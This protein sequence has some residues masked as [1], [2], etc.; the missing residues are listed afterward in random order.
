M[1]DPIKEIAVYKTPPARNSNDSDSSHQGRGI[2]VY[3]NTHPTQAPRQSSRSHVV[4]KNNGSENPT[5]P[6]D[7][8]ERQSAAEKFSGDGKDLHGFSV[9]SHS[10]VFTSKQVLLQQ[11]QAETKDLM[12]SFSGASASQLKNSSFTRNDK[13][14][15]LSQGLLSSQVSQKGVELSGKLENFTTWSVFNQQDT[16]VNN[17]ATNSLR[18][19]VETF[20]N[21]MRSSL[22]N[23][24]SSTPINTLQHNRLSQFFF[25][26]TKLNSGAASLASSLFVNSSH[27]DTEGMHWVKWAQQLGLPIQNMHSVMPMLTHFQEASPAAKS[28]LQGFMIFY[29]IFAGVSQSNLSN[30]SWML[31]KGMMILETRTQLNQVHSPLLD[32]LGALLS[33]SR[34][35]LRRQNRKRASGLDKVSRK[36]SCLA[37]MDAQETAPDDEALIDLWPKKESNNPSMSFYYM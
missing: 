12:K 14:G 10:G 20:P 6:Q 5:E 33:T 25:S 35:R 27:S 21:E 37:D 9:E 29:G 8:F 31:L 34:R 22:S 1:P 11:I 26:S 17:T 16:S 3:R 18:G 28:F 7:H 32:E 23:N 30:L 24:S 36:D 19:L 2:T 13:Q 4:E 15:P